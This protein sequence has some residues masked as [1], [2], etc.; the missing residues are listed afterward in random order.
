MPGLPWGLEEKEPDEDWPTELGKGRKKA[1]QG[2]RRSLIRFFVKMLA[3]T[4]T[5]L[6]VN[7]N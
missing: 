6:N 5:T 1:G 2:I 7:C 4:N 3:R